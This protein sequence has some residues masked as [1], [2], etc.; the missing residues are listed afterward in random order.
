[1]TT[2]IQTVFQSHLLKQ[3]FPADLVVSLHECLGG[4][5]SK[6]QKMSRIFSW[7]VIPRY[8]VILFVQSVIQIKGMVM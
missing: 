3:T 4:D 6:V 7:Y 8:K 2:K 5:I 1:M